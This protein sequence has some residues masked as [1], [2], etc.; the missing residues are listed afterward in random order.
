[1]I[2]DS[3]RAQIMHLTGVYCFVEN[4]LKDA[5]YFT[6]QSI[7]VN[8]SNTTNTKEQNA[9][10][11]LFNL[12]Y[13]YLQS[14]RQED[15]ILAYKK[16]ISIGF[17]YKASQDLVAESYREYC[18]ILYEMGEYQK[19][20]ENVKI[21]IEKIDPSQKKY[22]GQLHRT[23]SHAL[24]GL[25]KKTEALTSILKS[26]EIFNDLPEEKEEIAHNF[27]TLGN[28]YRSLNEYSKAIA[29]LKKSN[30]LFES[31]ADTNN[32]SIGLLNI[33]YTLYLQKQYN[34][35]ENNFLKAFSI[36]KTKYTASRILDNLSLVYRGT[37]D[38]KKALL[39]SHRAIQQS[40]K[41]FDTD[42]TDALPPAKKIQTIIHQEYLFSIIYN[43][44]D[45]W[46]D[47]YRATKTKSHLTNALKTYALADSMIDFMRYEHA[48]EGSKLFWRQK[49]R[50]MYERAI[51]ACYLAGDME[52]AFRFFEK[53]KAVLLADKL[54]ELGANQ[55][56]PEADTKRQKSLRDSL[57]NLQNQLASLA[58]NDKK[59]LVL[60]SRLER[61]ND[62]FEAF[63]KNLEKTNPAYYRYKYDN[64]TPDIAAFKEKAFASLGGKGAFV[65]YFVGDSAVYAFTLRDQAK[66][67][68]LPIKP[69]EYQTLANEF[70]NLCAD[71][72][73]LNAHYARYRTL[74]YS[75][76][77]HL[78]L[79]LGITEKRVTISSDGEFLPFEAL[80]S[81]PTEDAFLLKK[82]A[83]SYTYSANFLMKNNT[84]RKTG[85]G[86]NSF[87]GFAPETFAASLKQATLNG[88]KTALE[89]VENTFF[90]GKTFTNTE[91]TKAQFL[92]FAP[93]ARVIQLFTHAVAG[94]N[95]T[96]EPTIY[97][98]DA[99]LR[100]SELNQ[101]E[102]FDTQL[103]V[104][105]ACKTGV[106]QNQRGEGV[107]SLARGFAALG[108]G[109]TVTTL[110]NVED[111]PTY[112]LTKLFYNHLEQGLPK[113]EALQRAKLEW[114]EH[115][116]QADALPSQW[117]GMILV[118]DVHP[119]SVYHYPLILGGSM[120]LLLVGG[121]IWWRK[122]RRLIRK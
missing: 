52:Q 61:F 100:L 92:S 21:G 5:I 39:F 69:A 17:K 105:S 10:R 122:K 121:G 23:Q 11:S 78:W 42:R 114:I 98:Q 81:A 48:G 28:I 4:N 82:H 13:F 47:Y 72:A 51:E 104:L 95:E 63:R 35:S 89:A 43:K 15:A 37:K 7:A 25:E 44:A 66:L 90:L 94:P 33:G 6:G 68:R 29:A 113:D 16:C 84:P 85:L 75:L 45:T 74:A 30:T 46:L 14:N 103:L 3:L 71:R 55:Q 40:V 22:I 38:F 79:P 88:S 76:Y 31:L 24:R 116:G 58:A 120:V 65:S 83:I 8:L 19:S 115:G 60:Q 59:R 12:A 64:S 107:F 18:R 101:T 99:P 93:S 53:S 77:Q 70:L 86:S 41:N 119:L 106:G 108:I 67:I 112:E 26:I 91:A 50:G 2:R 34:E 87:V 49:T 73:T 102:G 111:Q 109:S 1:M 97:F 80:L 20:Y 96:A 117:A 118:G 36:A 9:V 57:S 56:L 27:V 62:D 110:W 54:N 32:L